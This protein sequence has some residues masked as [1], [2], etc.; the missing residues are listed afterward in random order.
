MRWNKRPHHPRG[1]R[2]FVDSGT[3]GCPVQ[4]ASVDIERCLMCASFEDLGEENGESVLY[5]RPR[6]ST[7]GDEAMYM[8]F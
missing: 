4:H 7:L 3:V 1:G 8:P 6:G 2:H 5:C